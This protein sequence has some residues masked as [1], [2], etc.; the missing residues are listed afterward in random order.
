MPVMDWTNVEQGF[1]SIICQNFCHFW[2]LFKVPQYLRR[3]ALRK[4]IRN[5]K[6][7]KSLFN[8]LFKPTYKKNPKPNFWKPITNS[9]IWNVG[10]AQCSNNWGKIVQYYNCWTRLFF[11]FCYIFAI[12]DDFTTAWACAEW[13]RS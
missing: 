8:P 12:F 3:T 9:L 1:S 5:G 6:W 11:I 2:W 13:S 10:E 4:I 7:K